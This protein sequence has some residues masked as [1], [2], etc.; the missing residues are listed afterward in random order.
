MSPATPTI[1]GVRTIEALAPQ[2]KV[3]IASLIK[4]NGV[5]GERT[6]YLSIEPVPWWMIRLRRKVRQHVRRLV[7]SSA[8]DVV[9]IDSPNG[10]RPYR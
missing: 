6:Q 9:M 3:A 8:C 10:W 1:G 7:E 5:T 4:T 2:R